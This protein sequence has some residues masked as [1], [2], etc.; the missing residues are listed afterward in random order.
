MAS[1]MLSLDLPRMAVYR[2]ARYR[3]SCCMVGNNAVGKQKRLRD[4]YH[5]PQ[6]VGLRLI[7]FVE[8]KA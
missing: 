5:R 6:N 4:Y 1:M 2:L 8:I 7:L 3:P